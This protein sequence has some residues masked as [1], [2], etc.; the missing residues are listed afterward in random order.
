MDQHEEQVLQTLRE[1]DPER[2][3]ACLY[4][5]DSYRVAAAAIYA[6][7][8]EI[9]RIP[10]LISEPM[11]GEIRLQWWRDLISSRANSSSAGALADLL[12]QTIEKH[13]LPRE[14]FIN[15]LDARLIDLY[16]DP[17]PDQGSFEGYLGETTSS[18]L[19]LVSL[20]A[21]AQTSKTLADACGHA[22]MA[23]GIVRLVSQ[24][25]SYRGTGRI[26]FP[27]ALLK[28]CGLDRDQWL[29]GAPD[30]RHMAVLDEMLEQAK[31]HL[32]YS[33]EAVVKL[34]EELH[35]VF[36]PLAF[37]TPLLRKAKAGGLGVFSKSA[38]LN[39]LHR[40]FV[41]FKAGVTGR[42]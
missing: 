4:L 5:P 1:L 14:T 31:S 19:Q 39:A 36:L 11:P 7:D 18:L 24:L 42:I 20:C 10:S 9:S 13:D 26:Y 37:V 21:G 29:R 12:L 30:E 28:A 33:R 32:V 38:K 34:P 15:Y 25:P 8:A 16:Q 35:P 40:Q 23:L 17:M 6:F 41:A 22:G 2:Y 3:L 27:M